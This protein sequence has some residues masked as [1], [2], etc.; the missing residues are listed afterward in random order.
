MPNS[1]IYID[2]SGTLPDTSDPVV[3]VAAVGII[4]PERIDDIFKQVRKKTVSKKPKREIKYYTA[5]EK[6]KTHF[7]KQPTT[8]RSGC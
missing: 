5:G 4:S 6:T 7:Y 8:L 1:I 2:E 3:I